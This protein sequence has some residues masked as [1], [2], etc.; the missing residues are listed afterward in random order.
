MESSHGNL[1]YV[2]V[3][4]DLFDYTLVFKNE[5][6][7]AYGKQN[8]LFGQFFLIDV[9]KREMLKTILIVWEKIV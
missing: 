3:E 6:M 7:I 8:V 4:F 1:Y 9:D 5:T 2:W